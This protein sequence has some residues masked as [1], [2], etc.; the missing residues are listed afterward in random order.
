MFYGLTWYSRAK[1]YHRAWG[2]LGLLS[3]PGWII[4]ACIPDRSDKDYRAFLM[5]RVKHCPLCDV[6]QQT[7]TVS[8]PECGF[9]FYDPRDEGR[10]TEAELRHD[11]TTW[12]GCNRFF[13]KLTASHLKGHRSTCKEYETQNGSE[14]EQT[15]PTLSH[16]AER[17]EDSPHRVNQEDWVALR[18]EYD[19]CCRKWEYRKAIKLAQKALRLSPKASEAWRMVGN[20]YGCLGDELEAGGNSVKA[21]Y[22]HKRATEAWRELKRREELK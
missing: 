22:F 2:F 16:G 20:A 18:H 13:S 17:K 7:A 5:R 11:G 8:C 10:K 4:L 9:E 1:G 14:T 15:F 3:F 6:S 12:L 19:Q 21:E